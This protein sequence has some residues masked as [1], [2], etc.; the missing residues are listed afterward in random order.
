KDESPVHIV[1]LDAFWIDKFEVTNTQYAL[2]LN[3]GVCKAPSNLTSNARP[4]YFGI[5]QFNNYPVVYVS[6]EDAS[7][8]CVWAGRRL[9]TEAE[10]EKAARGSDRRSYPW[11]RTF[12][13]NL[14]NSFDKNLLN[15]FEGGKGDTTLV[16]IY[17][18]GASPYG[19][20]DMAGNVWE[21]TADWYDDRYYANSPRNNP[22]GPPSGSLRVARGGSWWSGYYQVRTTMRSGYLAPTDRSNNY[23][24]RCAK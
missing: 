6:W 20:L 2:C 14:L 10:W 5:P 21:W 13:K 7:K 16:G 24:F 11:G 12:E 4:G 3:A 22:Q 17:S 1:Y 8:Y 15:F 19:A 9:P 18:G 23:G